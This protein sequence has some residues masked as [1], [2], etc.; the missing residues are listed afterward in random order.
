LSVCVRVRVALAL[1]LAKRIP[2][3]SVV[4]LGD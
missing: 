2:T 3:A 4:G 1:A